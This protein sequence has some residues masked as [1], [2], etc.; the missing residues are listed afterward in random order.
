M[1]LE[2]LENVSSIGVFKIF[3]DRSQETGRSWLE[4]K[5]EYFVV[6]DNIANSI[7][8]K[9]QNGPIKEHGVNG[10]QIDTII[11]AA[12]LILEGLNSNFPCRDNAIAITKLDEA[13]MW[14]QK[15]TDDR[16]KRSVEGTNQA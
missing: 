16:I 12:K 10:C 15:R 6:I 13:L 11:E 7:A 3:P 9:I 1:A 8:F 14:R 5:K 4:M 2:T